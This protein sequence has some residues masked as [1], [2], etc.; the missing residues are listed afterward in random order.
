MDMSPPPVDVRHLEAL[1]AQ[2]NA[3]APCENNKRG[4]GL[5]WLKGRK[6]GSHCLDGQNHKCVQMTKACVLDGL[7]YGL[8][9]DDQNSASGLQRSGFLPELQQASCKTW[10][11]GQD[12]FLAKSCVQISEQICSTAEATPQHRRNPCQRAG[13]T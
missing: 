8:P 11:R 3:R 12:A 6:L 10:L 1:A 5:Q 4:Q 2:F 7:C 9:T 13:A